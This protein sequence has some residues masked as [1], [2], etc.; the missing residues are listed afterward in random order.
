MV[1]TRCGTYLLASE[2]DCPFRMMRHPGH[3][4]SGQEASNWKNQMKFLDLGVFEP[5]VKLFEQKKPNVQF[6]EQ[7]AVE[8]MSI[9]FMVYCLIKRS[10]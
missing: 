2:L 4:P 9:V 1:R 5:S 3:R 7:T 6:F 10:L 8:H